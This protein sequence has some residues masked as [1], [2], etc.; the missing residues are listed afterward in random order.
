MDKKIIVKM[1]YEATEEEYN[2][3]LRLLNDNPRD[4]V[5][6]KDIDLY[7]VEVFENKS[8]IEYKLERRPKG[9]DELQNELSKKQEA[10]KSL[11]NVC[12][13]LLFGFLFTIGIILGTL[14]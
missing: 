7:V 2:R 14:I 10:I 13:Y 4:L 11:K 9:I 1:P 6:H 12:E 8:V 5:I 3:M